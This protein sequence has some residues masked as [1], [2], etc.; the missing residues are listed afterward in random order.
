MHSVRLAAV[1]ILLGWVG[2]LARAQDRPTGDPRQDQSDRQTIVFPQE[3]RAGVEVPVADSTYIVGPGDEIGISILGAQFY[4][5]TVVVSSDGTIVIPTLGKIYIRNA[6]LRD[7]RDRIHAEL[8]QDIKRAD[9]IVSLAKARSVKVTVS[10]AVRNPGIVVMP[11]SGRVSEALELAGG[12]MEDTTSLRGIHVSRVDGSV[13]S[14]DLLRYT[15]I[16]DLEANPFVSGGDNIYFAPRDAKVGI[17][18]SVGIEGVIDYLPGETLYRVLEGCQGLRASAFR[19]SVE[20]VRFNSDHRT[21][22]R[23]FLD[24]RG[25][26]DDRSADIPIMP[27]DLILI[28]AIPE[29]DRHRLIIVRGEVLY[30]GS[31]AIEEGKTTLRDAIRRAGGFTAQASLEEAIVIRRPPENERDQEFERL[32]KIPAADMREDEYEYYKARS[33]ERLGQMVVNFKRLFLQGIPSEDIV[34]QDGDV[35]EIPKLKNYIRVIGRVNNPGNVIFNDQW[36]FLQYIA[37]TGGFG[38]RA[39]DNDVRIVKARTGELVDASDESDYEL[40]PGD[41]IWVP[42]EPETK[43]WATALTVLGVV[44]QI[45]GILGIVIAISRVR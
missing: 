3:V 35:I 34:L 8:K 28:R 13:R 12:A 9:V 4:T 31:F 32:Q 6:T 45:A 41:T 15:R 16:G 39:Q 33:R 11:S 10:G 40:E 29:Y 19:D 23:M 25:Y 43:F 5:Y 42:E 7:V 30:P 44:S 37:A 20:I 38:W 22:S 1:L 17:Y 2:G 27:N 26:P 24:L 14:A 18:G 36:N 21:T